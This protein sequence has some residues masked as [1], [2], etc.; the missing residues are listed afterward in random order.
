MPLHSKLNV[1]VV[2]NDYV[3]TGV[4]DER[5]FIFG[6]LIDGETLNV[7]KKFAD[8]RGC[9]ELG[10]NYITNKFIY[11]GKEKLKKTDFRSER[12]KRT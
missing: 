3:V 1:Q 4:S 10:V 11:L 2:N 8:F 12:R 5:N 7:K 9:M 6:H